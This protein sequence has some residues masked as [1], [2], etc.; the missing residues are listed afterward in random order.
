[1]KLRLAASALLLSMLTIISPALAADLDFSDWELRAT[2]IG[3]APV[4]DVHRF[5]DITLPFSNSHRSTYGL[6]SAAASYELDNSRFLI[7]SI[8]AAEAGEAD[9]LL[10]AA[11][12]TFDVTA[13]RDVVVHY[14]GRFTFNLTADSMRAGIAFDF[15][16]PGNVLNTLHEDLDSHFTIDGVGPGV[17]AFSGEFVIPAFTTWDVDYT[18]SIRAND[19]SAGHIAT[20]TGYLEFRFSP[21][22]ATAA[23]FM[24]AGCCLRRTRRVVDD[25][26]RH[27]ATGPL[28]CGRGSVITRSGLIMTSLRGGESPGLAP[29][30]EYD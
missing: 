16:E 18:M 19:T 22:P 30:V 26:R 25:A 13:Q 5:N 12:G 10:S 28:P 21:E 7:R 2:V 14:D 27:G 3:S 15:S 24:L 4:Y 8:I 23:L 11:A 29:C 20:G 17:L 9:T 6:S 1:M